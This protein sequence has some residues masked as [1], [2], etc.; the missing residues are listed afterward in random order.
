MHIELWPVKLW[1]YAS[2]NMVKVNLK[3]F[4]CI[5]KA[6]K[7]SDLFAPAFLIRV[8]KCTPLTQHNSLCSIAPIFP[9]IML[10]KST[11]AYNLISKVFSHDI[12]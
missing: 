10:A 6:Y 9:K 4:H 12:Y 5:F 2:L 1:Y 3:I 11:K 7:F 8:R